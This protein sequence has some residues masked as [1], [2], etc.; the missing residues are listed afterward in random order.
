M[1]DN[2]QP[3]DAGE[4]P[5]QPGLRFLET[6]VYIMGGLLVLMLVVLL[7]GI[8]WKVST[9]APEEPAKPNL[10]EL[11]TPAGAQ[12]QSVTL[13]GDRMAI[14]VVSGGAHEIIVVDTK[15]AQV[16]SRVTLKPQAP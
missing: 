12:V 11:S 2:Q 7:G 3:A 8:A 6:T 4:T 5:P 9:R 13:D 10:V 14:H 1:T 16:L 15:K